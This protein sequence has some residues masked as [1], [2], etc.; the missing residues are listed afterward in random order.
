MSYFSLNNINLH[1]TALPKSY[2]L[3][4]SLAEI[5]NA[6]RYVAQCYDFTQKALNVL[7]YFEYMEL[8]SSNLRI[9]IDSYNL[10]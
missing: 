5:N 4:S 3:C 2:I 1:E 8:I 10:I 9:F 7:T 6:S